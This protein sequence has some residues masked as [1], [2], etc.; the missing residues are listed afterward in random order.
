MCHHGFNSIDRMQHN[1]ALIP[2]EGKWCAAE[3]SIVS[4]IHEGCDHGFQNFYNSY[5]MI[6]SEGYL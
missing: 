2:L 4:G 6:K 1:L 5:T 3:G